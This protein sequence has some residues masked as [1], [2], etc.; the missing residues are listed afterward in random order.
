MSRILYGLNEL[1]RACYPRSEEEA[2]DLWHD[3][4]PLRF[5]RSVSWT[6]AGEHTLAS[7]DIPDDAA[8][9][10]VTAVDF[11]IFT[12]LP[13]APGFGLKGPPPENNPGGFNIRWLSAPNFTATDSNQSLV[14]GLELP[15]LLLDTDEFLFFKGGHTIRL[16]AN[17]VANPTAD[18]RRF[19]TTVHAYIIGPKVAD[20]LG[21]GETLINFT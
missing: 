8:Y 19:R 1:V 5:G 18:V 17:F 21:S 14:T 9:L 4:K 10:I 7:Y 2:L 16:R 13:T 20:R 3:I 6:T 15:Y 11:Y 12:D